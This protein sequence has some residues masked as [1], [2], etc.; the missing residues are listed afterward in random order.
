MEALSPIITPPKS[1]AVLVVS[2]EY[3]FYLPSSERL[4]PLARR[5]AWGLLL[6]S[7]TLGIVSR[8]LW[9]KILD[10]TV[11][12]QQQISGKSYTPYQMQPHHSWLKR[13]GHP[14]KKN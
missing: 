1:A 6:G 14:S 11:S 2:Y 10:T 4:W 13:R 7:C 5:K 9:L 8:Q 3:L 12:L